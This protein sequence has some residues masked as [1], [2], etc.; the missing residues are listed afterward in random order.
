MLNTVNN[1][2]VFKLNTGLLIFLSLKSDIFHMIFVLPVLDQSNEYSEVSGLKGPLDR[3]ANRAKLVETN[4]SQEA[5]TNN[6]VDPIPA[7][8]TT[9]FTFHFA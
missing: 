7:Q 1:E 5:V 6:R 2:Q 9:A 8:S 3:C 4:L